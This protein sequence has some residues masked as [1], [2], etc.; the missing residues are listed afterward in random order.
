M[1]GRRPKQQLQSAREEKMQEKSTIT[2]KI[3]I[4]TRQVWDEAPLFYSL[5]NY[6]ILPHPCPKPKPGYVDESPCLFIEKNNKLILAYLNLVI[7]FCLDEEND[8]P[9]PRTLHQSIK[10]SMKKFTIF[11]PI[12]FLKKAKNT[13]K[14]LRDHN[15]LKKF[16]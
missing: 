4:V 16:F 6:I 12:H 1:L 5:P 14:I 9:K 10:F 7:Y 2:W 3:R 13:T 15:S 11:I 8:F